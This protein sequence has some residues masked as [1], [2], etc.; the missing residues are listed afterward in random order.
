MDKD[1]MIHQFASMIASH[2]NMIAKNIIMFDLERGYTSFIS[3]AAL[4]G[5]N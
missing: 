3:I 5:N 2:V 1:F 4:Q